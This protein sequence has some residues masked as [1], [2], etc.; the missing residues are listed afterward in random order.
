P[1][2]YPQH[3]RHNLPVVPTRLFGREDEVRVGCLLL[4]ADTRLLTLTGAGGIGKTRLGLEIAA[5]LVD[6]FPD[7]AWFVDL[8]PL[9]DRELLV[10][11][12]ARVLGV[13]EDASQPLQAALVRALRERHLLLV[14][15]NCEHLIG[16]CA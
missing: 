11:A 2:Q 13:R 9:A 14:L 5:A 8:A 3:E 1:P 7:G 6:T 4:R 16:G 10:T 12:V 15:D